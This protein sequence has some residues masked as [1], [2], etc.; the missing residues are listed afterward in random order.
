MTLMWSLRAI[1]SKRPTRMAAVSVM[2][3]VAKTTSRIRSSTKS[4]LKDS[5]TT[6]AM[7]SKKKSKTRMIKTT[8]AMMKKKI[9]TSR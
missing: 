8:R 3:R 6:T 2:E 9:M 5:R 7:K 4:S 1:S